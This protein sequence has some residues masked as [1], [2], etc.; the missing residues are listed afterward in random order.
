MGCLK[1]RKDDQAVKDWINGGTFYC[2]HIS[3]YDTSEVTDMSELFKDMEVFN[4][5]IS[6]WN[7]SNVT[8]IKGMFAG[9]SNFD[10]SIGAWSTGNVK[11]MRSMFTGATAFNEDYSKSRNEINK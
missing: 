4:D 3:D 6:R 1:F 5:H 11:Y 2:G 7:L 8:K 10:Q 9:A